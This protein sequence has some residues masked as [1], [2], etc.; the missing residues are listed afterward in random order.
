MPRSR[1][2]SSSS[3]IP[4]ASALWQTSSNCRSIA[5]SA[6]SLCGASLIKQYTEGGNYDKERVQLLTH[7]ILSHHGTREFGAVVCP[8]ISEA[9][10]LYYIDNIDAKLYACEDYYE[11]LDPKAITD[12]KPFGLDNRIYRPSFF[13]DEEE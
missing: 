5:L 9:F 4:C 2:C 12:K 6:F 11:S 7:M 3:L 13:D 1:F 10:V 8:A